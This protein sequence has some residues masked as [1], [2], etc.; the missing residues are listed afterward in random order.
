MLGFKK[1]EEIVKQEPVVE[2]VKEETEKVPVQSHL[3]NH[4]LRYTSTL[5][6]SYVAWICENI[7]EESVDPYINKDSHFN[8]DFITKTLES[9]KQK[10][11]QDLP[12]DYVPQDTAAYSDSPTGS[13]EVNIV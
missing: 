13:I 12:A 2:E 7:D 10:V 9:A 11:S 5:D 8:D 4:K 1:Q 3:E 6:I